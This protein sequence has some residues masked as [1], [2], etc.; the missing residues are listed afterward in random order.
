MLI[1]LDRNFANLFIWKPHSPVGSQ[2]RNVML[3]GGV[4]VYLD[5]GEWI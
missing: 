4:G 5:N 3:R 2:A 1:Y